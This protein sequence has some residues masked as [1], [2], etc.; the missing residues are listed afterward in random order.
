MKKVVVTNAGRQAGL[1]FCQS[2]KLVPNEYHIIGLDDNKYS[3]LQAVADEKY[4]SPPPNS[5]Y[6]L[7]FLKSILDN[8][9]VD[10][11]YPSKT[12]EEL[13]IIASH[14]DELNAKVFLPENK[15]IEIYEDKFKTYQCLSAAGIPVPNTI[16]VTGKEVLQEFMRVHKQV[17]LRAIKGC[18]G[19][20]SISTDSFAFACTWI[21][22]FNGWGYF[23]AAEMLSSR[24]ATWSGIWDNGNL[25]VSQV[26]ERKYWEFAY[27]SPSGVSGVTGAQMTKQD[28][29]IDR[30]ALESIFAVEKKP[31][32]IVSVDFCYDNAG[33]PN[34]TEIQ[35]SRFF[36]STFFMAKAGLNLPHIMI[37]VA[38]G[39]SNIKIEKKYSPL[40]EGLVW[41]KYVDCNPI[42]TTV[43]EIEKNEKELKDWLIN[44]ER[45]KSSCAATH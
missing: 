14:R 36:S 31:H 11:L 16:L 8:K 45:H 19:K 5:P 23:T 15:S 3:L 34:P 40:P 42:L 21:D 26:R 22:R 1:N 41:I 18:G 10:F 32:G 39:E 25:I 37:Q 7:D 27:A 43:Q 13:W 38:F 20:G 44:R 17:W 29:T 12:N 9:N 30:L 24:T 33:I 6:Y 4:L 35:G 2:L 28:P